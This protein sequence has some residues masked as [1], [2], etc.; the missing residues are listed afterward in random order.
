MRRIHLPSFLI[1]NLFIER[2]LRGRDHLEE[3]DVDEMIILNCNFKNYAREYEL[4]WSVTGYR[5]LAGSCECGNEHLSSINCAGFVD[6][7][8]NC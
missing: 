5:Q 4:D 2:V 8:R 3:L 1:Y 7:L 6:K